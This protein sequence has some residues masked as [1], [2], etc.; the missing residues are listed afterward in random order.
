M[1]YSSHPGRSYS[2]HPSECLRDKQRRRNVFL[3]ALSKEK[4]SRSVCVYTTLCLRHIHR[5]QAAALDFAWRQ[6]GRDKRERP[7]ARGMP[8]SMSYSSHQTCVYVI[9]ITSSMWRQ[10]GRDQEGETNSAR[11]ACVYVIFTTSRMK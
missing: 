8:V 10:I 2:S 4:H 9:F 1:S 6:I 5:I 11:Y 3:K 7:I